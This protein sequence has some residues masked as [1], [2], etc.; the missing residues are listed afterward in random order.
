MRFVRDIVLH[1]FTSLDSV[2]ASKYSH[3]IQW[4]RA[5]FFTIDNISLTFLFFA[6]GILKSLSVDEMLLLRYLKN[7]IILEVCFLEWA[8]VFARSAWNSA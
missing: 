7:V 4:D 6:R 5:D 2:T 1:H 3:F 8:G